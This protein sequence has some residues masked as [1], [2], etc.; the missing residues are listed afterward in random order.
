M[1][2][3]RSLLYTQPPESQVH[4]PDICTRHSTE[5]TTTAWGWFLYHPSSFLITFPCN[6]PKALLT[7]LN[8]TERTTKAPVAVAVLLDRKEETG[9]VGGQRQKEKGPVIKHPCWEQNLWQVCR[10]PE[11]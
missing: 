2:P 5:K 4:P 9:R 3:V 10:G 1:N 6:L 11:W 8:S 7:H